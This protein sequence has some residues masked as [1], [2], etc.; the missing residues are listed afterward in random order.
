MCT[1]TRTQQVQAPAE[2]LDRGWQ[3]QSVI[4]AQVSQPIEDEEPAHG[5]MLRVVHE[6]ATVTAPS[7][8]LG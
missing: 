5:D 8:H 4:Q 2:Y 1:C 6:G 7:Y 3:G